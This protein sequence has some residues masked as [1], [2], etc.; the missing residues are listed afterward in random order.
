MCQACS[1]NLSFE[2]L[3]EIERRYFSI[4]PLRIVEPSS[5]PERNSWVAKGYREKAPWLLV[6]AFGGEGRI[7]RRRSSLRAAGARGVELAAMYGDP[8]IVAR[9][10][11]LSGSGQPIFESIG[12]VSTHKA[13][14]LSPEAFEAWVK[15]IV[16]RMYSASRADLEALSTEALSHLSINFAGVDNET[17]TKALQGYRT[18]I[19]NPTARMLEAQRVELSR[20]L[21]DVLRE[22][23]VRAKR[24]PSVRANLAAG[25]AVRDREVSGL[26]ARHHSF[27]VRDRHGAIS[28][29]MSRRA[30]DIISR[31]VEEGMGR[32]DIGQELSRMTASGMR[33]P[34]YYQNVAAV[35]VS[36]ARSYSMGETMQA[37][38][39]EY[40]RIEAV[41]DIRTTYECEFLHQKVIPIGP[42]VDAINRTLNSADP[43]AVLTEQPFL[44]DRGDRLTIPDGKGGERTLARIESRGDR[45]AGM[46]STF[47][48][49]LSR[50]DLADA[51]VG[52]PPYHFSCR[53]TVVPV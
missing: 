39:I 25:F 31:G 42:S 30:R 3:R 2:I 52:F 35:Q 6:S 33:Q 38:G 13:D 46:P 11:G 50:S 7:E 22:T 49:N 14:P 27:W 36:R 17:L 40:F 53:T 34:A 51:R 21:R 23:G 26:L 5:D 45:S 19:A 32:V 29:S 48:S 43:E 37:A 9:Q 16:S 1:E 47:T 8:V 24:F 10:I 20:T 41:L 12:K 18:T 28:E 15:Q 44:R 4:L